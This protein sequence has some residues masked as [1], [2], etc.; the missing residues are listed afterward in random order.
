MFLL[1]LQQAMFIKRL[2]KQGC[3]S[4]GAVDLKLNIKHHPQG[5]ELNTDLWF[6]SQI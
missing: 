6:V 1:K 4:L 3:W 5:R 2:N